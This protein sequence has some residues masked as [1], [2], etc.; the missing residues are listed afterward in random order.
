MQH[1]EFLV[2]NGTGQIKPLQI[3][4][5][6]EDFIDHGQDI[7]LQSVVCVMFFV[8]V[9]CLVYPVLPVSLDCSFLIALP[10]PVFFNVYLQYKTSVGTEMCCPKGCHYFIL[11]T[12]KK[13]NHFFNKLILDY[14]F[15]LKSGPVF[16][17]QIF[18]IAPP[19]LPRDI[20]LYH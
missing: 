8:F 9:L 15:Y 16:L 4:G 10:P 3:F 14:H 5:Y 13:K 7:W 20:K 2:S 1:E 12:L 18:F 17:F 19:P 11:L 6:A